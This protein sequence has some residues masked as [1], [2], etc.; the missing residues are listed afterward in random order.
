MKTVLVLTLLAVAIACCYAKPS[1]PRTTYEDT[2][3][4]PENPGNY[5]IDMQL[6]TSLF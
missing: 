3:D 4:L 1:G 2:N 6:L 5:E